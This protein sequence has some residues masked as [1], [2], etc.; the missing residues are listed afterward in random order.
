MSFVEK[1]ME[2]QINREI[3]PFI[4]PAEEGSFA[5]YTVK[6][7]LPAIVDSIIA[8][9]PMESDE[10]NNLLQLRREILGEKLAN[11]FKGK[12]STKIDLTLFEN[13]ELKTWEKHISLYTGK[14]WFEV[15]WYFA[16]AFLYLR[17]LI[18]FGYYNRD[19]HNY[20]KDP[21]KPMKHEELQIKGGALERIKEILKLLHKTPQEKHVLFRELILL[22]LWGNR[23][24]LSYQHI[25]DQTRKGSIQTNDSLLIINDIESL[26]EKLIHSSNIHF[27]LDNSGTELLSDILLSLYLLADKT[28]SVTLHV[29]KHPFFVSD[30]IK[31]DIYIS[32]EAM[33]KSSVNSLRDFATSVETLIKNQHLIIKEHFF[34][35]GPCSFPE[36]P[37]KLAEELSLAD[38]CILKGDANY[39]RLLSDRKWNP[40]TPIEHITK[41]FPSPFAILRT[42]KSELIVGITKK[43]YNTLKRE[44]PKWL[45]NGKRGIIQLVERK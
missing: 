39:R 35:N 20:K 29:K 19:S 43:R 32:I 34:W 26:T 6:E 44:D 1:K 5:N 12:G 31:E 40:I 4:T 7:R 16:E 30:T 8:K 36:M 13:E 42:M 23:I 41:Y 17:I 18:A 45:I 28:K 15:P 14:T 22:S 27:I 3:P 2:K 25:V 9:N 10:K 37:K 21:F 11:P 33:K 24:D 38:L